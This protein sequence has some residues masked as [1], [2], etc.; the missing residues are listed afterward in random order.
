MTSKRQF[1]ELAK[2]HAED[3]RMLL[4]AHR[5]TN[6]VHLAGIAVECSLKALICD[7]FLEGVLPDRKIVERAH[8]HQLDDL[9]G[10]A[11]IKSQLQTKLVEDIAFEVRWSVVRSWSITTRYETISRPEATEFVSAAVDR[12]GIQAWIKTFW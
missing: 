1:Q 11:G 5:H 9:I 6:A 4:G 10:L 12:E 2:M 7:R 3:A 8:S